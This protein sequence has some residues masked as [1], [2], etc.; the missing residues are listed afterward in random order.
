MTPKSLSMESSTNEKPPCSSDAA[1]CNPAAPVRPLV[2]DPDPDSYNDQ[3]WPRFLV[4]KSCDDKSILKHNSFVVAKAIE[5]IAGKPKEVRALKHAGLL[6]IEVDRKHYAVNLLK[7]KLLHDIP[8]EISAHRTLNSAKGVFT[9]H[10]LDHMTDDEILKGLIDSDQNVKDMNRITTFKDGIK[11]GTNTFV[12]TFST[13]TLPDKIYISHYRVNV[14]LFIPNPRRCTNC[15]QF[16]HTKNFCKNEAVCGKCGQS[17]HDDKACSS[18]AICVNCHGDHK[19]SSKE[20]P[21][22]KK[23]KEI[24]HYKY[25]NNVSFPDARRKVEETPKVTTGLFM[26]LQFLKLNQSVIIVLKL[27]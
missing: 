3:N 23:E 10:N 27:I 19:A 16:N 24:V 9:C 1:A 11:V 17:G 22:W 14:R 12:V 13:T 18:D 5:G 2:A 20:C 6:L 8:V 25:T 26:P 7:A 4:V 15:Q 21:V